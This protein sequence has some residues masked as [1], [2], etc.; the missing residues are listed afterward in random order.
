MLDSGLLH[1]TRLSVVVARSSAAA[2][3]LGPDEASAEDVPQG[4]QFSTSIPGGF[5][6][7]TTSLSRKIDADYDDL[8]LLDDVSVI[9]PGGETAWQGRVAQLPRSAGDQSVVQVGAVG[10]ASHLRDD[11][12]FSEVYVDRDLASWQAPSVERKL[13]IMSVGYAMTEAS[14]QP[15]TS[16]GAPSLVTQIDGA[17]GSNTLPIS[18]ALY[19]AG[20]GNAIGSIYYAWK[21][22]LASPTYTDTQWSWN[23]GAGT[24]DTFTSADSTANLRAVGPGT[25]TLTTT[26]SNRRF[27]R[28]GLGYAAGTA[29]APGKINPV[30]WTCLA[31]Y[32]DHGLTKRG[33]SS[34]T[35]AQGFYGSD[36]IA[37]V[38]GRAAPLLNFSTGDGGSIETSYFSIPQLAF[39]EPTTA[40]EVILAVNAYHLWDWA[41]WNDRTFYW[42]PSNADRLTWTARLSDGARLDL[43]GVQADSVYN[44]VVATYADASGS[45]LTV[46]P[47]GSGADATSDLLADTTEENPVNAAGIPRRWAKLDISQTTTSAGAIQIAAT[48]LAEQNMPTRRGQL[49]ITGEIEHPT[50]GRVPVWQVRA[51]DYVTVADLTGGESARKIIETSYDHDT[52]TITLTLDNSAY[53][54]EAILERLGVALIGVL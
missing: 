42:Q 4:L 11:S 31:V 33:T 26:A 30:A 10:W 37:D 16:T 5:K 12:S 8:G 43:E 28:I 22:S 17:W 47:T 48:W 9:A 44:G 38:V 19:D 29:G 14:V 27:G 3:R 35:G 18:E 24:T 15:D 23:V 36:V 41:V 46:G 7:C 21:Q 53:K 52:R 25:G 49:A 1:R 50:K 51:G 13:S 20:S 54:V 6:D 40:E 2:T 34:A 32:G 45:Q 39:R